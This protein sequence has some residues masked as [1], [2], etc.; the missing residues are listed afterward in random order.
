M[1]RLSGDSDLILCLANFFFD[2]L[3]GATGTGGG[4]AAGAGAAGEGVGLGSVFIVTFGL[5]CNDAD[6]SAVFAG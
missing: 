2:F 1:T 5:G 3:A 6:G 4:W